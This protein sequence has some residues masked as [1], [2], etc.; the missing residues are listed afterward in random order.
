MN[1]SSLN[2]TG[3]LT[4]DTSE[5]SLLSNNDVVDK[6]RKKFQLSRNNTPSPIEMKKMKF[7][8]LINSEKDITLQKFVELNTTPII[9]FEDAHQLYLTNLI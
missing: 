9:E 6:K 5:N 8:K 4:I 3:S 1:D 2:T 7:G